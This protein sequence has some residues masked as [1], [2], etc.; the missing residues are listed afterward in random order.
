[1]DLQPFTVGGAIKEGWRLTKENLGFL[2]A[3]EI[4]LFLV[5]VLLGAIHDGFIL[6][7]VHFIGWLV[8]LL[9]K[10]GL[11]NSSLLITAGI[12]PGFD[13]MYKNYPLLLSWIIASI[14]FGIMFV[15]GLVLLI[16]PG[17]YVWAKYGFFPFFILD[18]KAGPIEALK[19]SGK[20]TE[21]IRW[22]I[23]L[24]FL[25]CLGLNL[26]GIILLGVGLLFT[27]PTTLLALA[28][29]YRRISSRIQSFNETWRSANLDN[30]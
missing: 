12:K 29:V 27:I 15:I 11:Y 1:M 13:Q 19:L 3:Y 2:L 4:I 25:A 26:L 6:A 18:K 22:H 9:I 21:G 28:I 24:L 23:F 7:I 8:C 10:L 17:L 30:R 5:C 14:L 20:A 16:V